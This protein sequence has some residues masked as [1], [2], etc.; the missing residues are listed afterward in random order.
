MPGDTEA[1]VTVGAVG[2]AGTAAGN[3]YAVT[4]KPGTVAEVPLTDLKDGSYTVTVNSSVPLVAGVRTAAIGTKSRDFSWF[5]AARPLQKELLAAVPAGGEATL[6]FANGGEA[7]KTVTVSGLTGGGK[8]TALKVTAEGGALLKVAP[9]A[10]RVTGADG[11]EGSISFAG[12]GR[13][14]SFAL[15]PPGPLAAP[16]TV[17]PN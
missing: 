9:G 11:L 3:S 16:I 5:S 4:V 12:D 6:H 7:D 17:Y 1:Q 10:Y 15:S 8:P 14:S 2:E 13:S